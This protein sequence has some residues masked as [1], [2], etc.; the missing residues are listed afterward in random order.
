MGFTGLRNYLQ[1]KKEQSAYFP[2]VGFA[3][4][5]AETTEAF[6]AVPDYL[7]NSCARR[8]NALYCR[9]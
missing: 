1:K 7:G 8:M 9:V 5:I 3:H 4:T 6:N 2:P